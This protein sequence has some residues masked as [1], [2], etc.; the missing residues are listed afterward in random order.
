MQ[1]LKN[2]WQS[3]EGPLKIG[4]S[5]AILGIILTI[6]GI[7]RDPTTPATVWSIG[8]GSLISGGVWG[9]VSWAIATAAMEVEEDV[10]QAEAAAE[11]GGVDE[12]DVSQ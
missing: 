2:W 1:W 6:I 11:A 10:R 3:R 9:I 8:M 7:I 5:F 4:I 12:L